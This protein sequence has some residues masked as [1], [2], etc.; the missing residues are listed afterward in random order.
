VLVVKFE[1]YYITKIA[2]LLQDSNN[3]DDDPEANGPEKKQPTVSE[4]NR[5]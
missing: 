2:Y 3:N 1:R 5:K 4:M